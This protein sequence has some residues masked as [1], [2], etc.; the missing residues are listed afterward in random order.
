MSKELVHSGVDYC[1][2]RGKK[3]GKG[4]VYVVNRESIVVQTLELL[5]E[6]WMNRAL[7]ASVIMTTFRLEEE[8]TPQ[9]RPNQGLF[10]SVNPRASSRKVD[11]IMIR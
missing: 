4:P 7:R 6:E 5:N 11:S 1:C 3:C 9:V 10:G 2:G 8:W